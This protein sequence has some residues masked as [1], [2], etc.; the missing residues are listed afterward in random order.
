MPQW[1]EDGLLVLC[2]EIPL[3]KHPEEVSVFPNFL[4]VD[5]E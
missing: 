3:H 4:E 1:A 5:V 2:S